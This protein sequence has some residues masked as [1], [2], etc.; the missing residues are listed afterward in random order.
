MSSPTH[1]FTELC[2]DIYDGYVSNSVRKDAILPGSQILAP[3]TKWGGKEPYTKT[4]RAGQGIGMKTSVISLPTEYPKI[5]HYGL[6][7]F[8]NA[9]TMW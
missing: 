1:A 2:A 8:M 7:V 3:L 4:V 5:S 6:F 9:I